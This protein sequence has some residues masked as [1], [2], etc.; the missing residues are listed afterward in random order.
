M[1]VYLLFGDTDELLSSFTK[2]DN[3]ILHA[4][5]TILVIWFAIVKITGESWLCDDIN[6]LNKEVDY[7]GSVC[8]EIFVGATI[9]IFM[10]IYFA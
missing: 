4:A 2:L 9:V 5:T 8:F 3:L 10:I 1:V 7:Y 6:S